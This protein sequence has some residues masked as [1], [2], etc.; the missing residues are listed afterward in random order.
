[1]STQL[2]KSTTDEFSNEE[3]KACID[4]LFNQIE[5]L[6]TENDGLLDE[7]TACANEVIFLESENERLELELAELKLANRSRL[8]Q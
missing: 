1:M 8:Q 2:H 7:I 5:Q 3:L 6:I 4:K